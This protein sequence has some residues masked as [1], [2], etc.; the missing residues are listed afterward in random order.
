M[1]YNLENLKKLREITGVGIRDCIKA[2]DASENDV[3]KSVEWLKERSISSSKSA[4]L[5]SGDKSN[6][7]GI[8]K[9]KKSGDKVVCFVLKCES[10][11]VAINSNFVNLAEQ[12]ANSLLEN[13]Y[14]FSIESAIEKQAEDHVKNLISE[15]SYSLKEKIYLEKIAFFLM[16]DN[17]TFG[18]YTHHNNKVASFVVLEGGDEAFAREIA[19]QVAAYNPSFLSSKEIPSSVL[20][21]KTKFFT[22]EVQ[23]EDSTKDAEISARIV[24]GKV[25]K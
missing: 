12:V 9:I 16:S 4:N 17:E 8:A 23:D 21:D 6:K 5:K 2:L 19:M 1:S 18:S 15:F 20:S 22:R 11:F 10:D 7:F 3:Q 14:H 25:N 24:T 13:F